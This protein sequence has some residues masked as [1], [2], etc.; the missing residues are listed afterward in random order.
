MAK[1]ERKTRPPFCNCRRFSA[2]NHEP[3]LTPLAEA[4]HQPEL[5]GRGRRRPRAKRASLGYC[6][7]LNQPR[8]NLVGLRIDP[9]H[10]PAIISAG[11]ARHLIKYPLASH[12]C[13]P[14]R[15]RTHWSRLRFQEHHQPDALSIPVASA[16]AL[17]PPDDRPRLRRPQI[18]RVESQTARREIAHHRALCFRGGSSDRSNGMDPQQK[19]HGHENIGAMTSPP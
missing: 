13:V 6:K 17:A 14:L 7:P 12:L 3:D 16:A 18:T 19:S 10:M 4:P 9:R 2:L 11:V 8:A 15:L 1:D 5:P